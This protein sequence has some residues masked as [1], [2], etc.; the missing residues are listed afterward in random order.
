LCT[1]II[2]LRERDAGDDRHLVLLDQLVD[3]LCGDLGLE[4]AVLLDH[5]HRHAAELAAVLLDDHHERVV[6]V[7]PERR[8]RPRQLGHEPDL[9]GRLRARAADGGRRANGGE[10]LDPLHAASSQ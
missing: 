4:L 2:T 5:L 7:L 3:E 10:C 6:L 1:A 9:D 8:L